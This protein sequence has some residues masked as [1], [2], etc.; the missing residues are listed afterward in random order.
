MRQIQ[1]RLKYHTRVTDEMLLDGTQFIFSGVLVHRRTSCKISV[2]RHLQSRLLI[3][4]SSSE[5]ESV[6]VGVG[7]RFFFLG[8]PS[9]A[10]AA[11]GL[12]A[13]RL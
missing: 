2:F 3:Y 4:H 8:P 6:K 7:R 9:S 1:P 10:A 11:S 13:R 5:D 12:S